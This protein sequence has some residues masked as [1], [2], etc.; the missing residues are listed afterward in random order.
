MGRKED[1]YSAALSLFAQKGFQQTT[2][3]AVARE[4]GVAE[5]L[6][7]H[8]FGT[9]AGILAAILNEVA[10]DFL[11]QAEKAIREAATGLAAIE[12]IMWLHFR[13]HNK[14]ELEF[15]VLMQEL[16]REMNREG[17]PT[18]ETM[19]QR[20]SG[21]LDRMVLCIEQGISD[22]SIRPDLDPKNMALII[23]SMVTGILRTIREIP[24]LEVNP[25]I[26]DQACAFLRDALSPRPREKSKG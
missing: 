12:S 10:D 17:S 7:F 9:K 24:G 13:F 15:T 5:G 4:A 20:L 21:L 26:E 2:T 11:G 6:I 14:R 1:I 18:A 3:A 19:R 22:G 16:P 23:H 8:H 25:G